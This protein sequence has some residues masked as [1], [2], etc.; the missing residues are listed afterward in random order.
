MR[1]VC[2]EMASCEH[3]SKSWISEEGEWDKVKA[4]RRWLMPATRRRM[5]MVIDFFLP[6]VST[7]AP[8]SMSAIGEAVMSRE[9]RMDSHSV[10]VQELLLERR[11]LIWS[12][13]TKGLL[14]DGSGAYGFP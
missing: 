2:R 6:R 12:C 9:E 7:S 4:P 11:E 10:G 14:V 3:Q 1:A 13:F 5:V 8:A